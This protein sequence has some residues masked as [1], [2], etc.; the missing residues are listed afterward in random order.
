MLIWYS[1]AGLQ[2]LYHFNNLRLGQPLHF[3]EK[4]LQGGGE[5]GRPSLQSPKSL[6]TSCKD[7]DIHSFMPLFC[8]WVDNC[9]PNTIPLEAKFYLGAPVGQW[10]VILNCLLNM[11]F[12]LCSLKKKKRI[13]CFSFMWNVSVKVFLLKY[14]KRSLAGYTRTS[15]SSRK[16]TGST[17]SVTTISTATVMYTHL[18]VVQ[19]SE[20]DFT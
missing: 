14:Q 7:T 11:F 20:L 9:R 6:P 1:S 8:Y 17:T 13:T 18:S 19:K 5:G 4:P 12:Y 15:V 3:P 10:R 16:R 2:Q